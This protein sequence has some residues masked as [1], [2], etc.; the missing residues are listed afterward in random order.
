MS[1]T[2][3]N[4]KLFDATINLSMEVNPMKTFCSYLNN[5][6]CKLDHFGAWG[7]SAMLIVFWLLY[8]C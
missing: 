4:F 5:L 3:G 8:L 2:E 6:L 1:E 7:K